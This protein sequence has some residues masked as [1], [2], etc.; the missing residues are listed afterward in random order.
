ML[1]TKLLSQAAS[2]CLGATA[3]LGVGP[4]R[5]TLPNISHAEKVVVPT[6]GRLE[7]PSFLPWGPISA[8]A[9]VKR[10]KNKKPWCCFVFLI[11]AHYHTLC[12]TA[13]PPI[14]YLFFFL[15]LWFLHA[16]VIL[17]SLFLTL[18]TTDEQT[19]RILKKTQTIWAERQPHTL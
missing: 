3:T 18:V 15:Q 14:K 11:K 5:T 16:I 17:T 4:L 19:L 9:R 10:K 13:P 2:K 8:T 1:S 7:T 12:T 6:G